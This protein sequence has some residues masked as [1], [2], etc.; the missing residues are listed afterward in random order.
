MACRLFPVSRNVINIPGHTLRVL[1]KL[2]CSRKE[3]RQSMRE[4]NPEPFMSYLVILEPVTDFCA[5]L[6][7]ST[8][9]LPT[10]P[11][12]SALRQGPTPRK[13]GLVGKQTCEE[14]HQSTG[15]GRSAGAGGFPEEVG[16]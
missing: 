6:R 2:E 4:W 13:C 14:E 10:P 12:C 15:K 1:G 7:L 8:K 3:S 16:L 11:V 9:H 5:L